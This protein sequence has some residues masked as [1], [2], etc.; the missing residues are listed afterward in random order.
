AEDRLSGLVDVADAVVATGATAEVPPVALVGEWEDGPAD[1]HP[2]LALVPGFLPRLAEGLDLIGLLGVEGLG[3]L[4]GLQRGALQ[5]HAHR[6]R[7][8]RGG[9]RGRAPPD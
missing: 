4:V 6:G 5:V 7:P 2:G 9:V 8:F 1:R 3:R